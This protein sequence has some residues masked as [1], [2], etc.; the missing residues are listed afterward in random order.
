M[1]FIN[2]IDDCFYKTKVVKK[3]KDN[4]VKIAVN[5]DF[6]LAESFFALAESCL[7]PYN[8]AQKRIFNLNDRYPRSN[9]C[10]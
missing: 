10:R 6:A 4:K 7:H 5:E 2:V 1:A 8:F 9:F 3:K